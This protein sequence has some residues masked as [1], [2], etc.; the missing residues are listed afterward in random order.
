[1]KMLY[2]DKRIWIEDEEGKT[3]GRTGNTILSIRA[4]T[5]R[6]RGRERR[7]CW[8][9]PRRITSAVQAVKPARRV[10]MRQRGSNGIRNTAIFT[11]RSVSDI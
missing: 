9:R 8:C 3:V 10:P 11:S 5:R 2:S 6:S 1:M 4:S 7:E